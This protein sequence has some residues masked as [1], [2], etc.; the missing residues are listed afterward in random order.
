MNKISFIIPQWAIQSLANGIDDDSL[1]FNDQSKIKSFIDT[2]RI[3]E[4]LSID[5]VPYFSHSND[6]ERIGGIVQDCL[7]MIDDDDE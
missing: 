1:S 5:S 6:I 2:E 3:I 4:F 7:F